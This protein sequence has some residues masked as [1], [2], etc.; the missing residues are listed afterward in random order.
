MATIPLNKFVRTSTV[1]SLS[2]P[3]LVSVYTVPTQRASI[4][5]TAQA[6]NAASI[7]YTASLYLLDSLSATK[8]F[9]AKDVSIAPND[10]VNLVLGKLVTIDGE[11]LF[12]Y[13][14]NTTG[15]VFFT[16]SIL[17]TLNTPAG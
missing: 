9:L 2:S 11:Q 16:L 10:A 13:T 4:V 7:P 8:T 6:T 15:E 12:A 14:D 1:L 17:E 3:S 5:L